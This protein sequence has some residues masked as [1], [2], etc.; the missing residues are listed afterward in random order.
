MKA[1]RIMQNCVCWHIRRIDDTTN[2][3]GVEI[4]ILH[5]GCQTPQNMICK[6]RDPAELRAKC[7]D[8]G[9]MSQPL[10]AQLLL[11]RGSAC[12]IRP[13]SVT[14]S[15]TA[16]PPGWNL[17]WSKTIFRFICKNVLRA[18]HISLASY[19]FSNDFTYKIKR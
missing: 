17:P 9:V 7:L 13:A 5:N 14:V 4:S 3:P 2:E 18:P 12:V 19:E 1:S 6:Q 11:K 8:S 15:S 10:R 16:H